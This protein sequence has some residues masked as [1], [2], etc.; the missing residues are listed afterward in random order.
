MTEPLTFAIR[1]VNCQ[2]LKQCGEGLALADEQIDVFFAKTRDWKPEY[3]SHGFLCS[4]TER[5]PLGKKGFCATLEIV[6]VPD[7]TPEVVK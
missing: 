5:C 1:Q 4:L 2:S 6:V 7:E 3:G